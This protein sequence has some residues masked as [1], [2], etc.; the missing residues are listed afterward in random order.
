MNKKQVLLQAIAP[1]QIGLNQKGLKPTENQTKEILSAVAY[2]E[3]SNPNP[4]PL[5]VPELLLGDWRLLFTSSKELLGL[6]RLPIIRTQ[7]IYQCIRDGKIYNIAEF[8]GF[9]FLEGFVSV[10]ASFTPVSRQRVNVRFERSVLGLQRLLNHKN[11]S[12]FVKIL[13]SKVKL[14]AVDFPITSTNQ[15]GWLETTY[16][17]ENLRIGRGNEGSIFVLERK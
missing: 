10:C 1:F 11:V 8:T 13:E 12:E 9:P 7:Y 5:E 16:L 14:P 17:D 3:E 2:L 6:D 4:S 15:K